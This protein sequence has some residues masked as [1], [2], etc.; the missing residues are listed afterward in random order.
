MEKPQIYL[1]RHGQS[2]GNVKD[3]FLG[4]TDWDLSELGYQQ[5][6]TLAEYF[7]SVSADAV[8]S[9]DLIRAYHT[10]LPTAK[11]KGLKIE[12]RKDLR[13]IDA[14]LWEAECFD[15]LRKKYPDSF[16][17]WCSDTSRCTPDGGESVSAMK[18]RFVRCVEALAKENLGKTILVFAHATPIR[19]LGAV[20]GEAGFDGLM[21]VPWPKNASVT[22]VEYA[23]GAFRLCSYAEDDFLSPATQE[24]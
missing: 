19:V 8:F 2:I 1:V 11:Q 3:A 24:I 6:E 15:D 23:D 5:A 16:G 18:D 7:R 22:H 9:S 14:G 13:E 4:H 21:E 17:D 10:A 12:T 20:W